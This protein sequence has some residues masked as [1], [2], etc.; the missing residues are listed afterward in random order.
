MVA[1]IIASIET[2]SPVALVGSKG[3]RH[4]ASNATL[5]MRLQFKGWVRQGIGLQNIPKLFFLAPST[6]GE[7]RFG[8]LAR[9]TNDWSLS[10]VVM[11]GRFKTFQRKTL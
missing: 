7:I 6:T 4:N 10:L 11:I 8:K 3:A 2:K 1:I 5:V 9:A